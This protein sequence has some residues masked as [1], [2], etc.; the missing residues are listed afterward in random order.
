S[1]RALSKLSLTG[2]AGTIEAGKPGRAVIALHG[3]YGGVDKTLWHAEGWLDP[4]KK[5]GAIKLRADRFTLDKIATVLVGPPV[6]SPE[7]PEIDAALDLAFEDGVLKFAGALDFSGL[8]IFHQALAD[9]PLHNLGFQGT[10]RG[11]YALDR[12]L[13]ALDEAKLSFRGV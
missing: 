7:Q 6:P 2:I 9:E 4:Q 13:L 8:T 11:S 12:R 1:A 5:A 10:V 3:G